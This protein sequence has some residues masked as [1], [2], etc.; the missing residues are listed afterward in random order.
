MCNIKDRIRRSTIIL[1]FFY[2][3]VIEENVYQDVFLNHFR[4]QKH[5]GIFQPNNNEH[6]LIRQQT[7]LLTIYPSYAHYNLKGK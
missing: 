7:K 2:S 6:G 4:T 1:W 3:M 5:I